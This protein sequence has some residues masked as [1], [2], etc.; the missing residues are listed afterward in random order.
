MVGRTALR[1]L[2]LAILLAGAPPL[3]PQ[4]KEAVL[5]VYNWAP[6]LYEDA[7]DPGPLARIVIGS[8][9]AVGYRVRVVGSS[10]ARVMEG[11]YSGEVDLSPGISITDERKG[12]MWFSAPLVNLKMG[13]IFKKGRIRYNSIDDLARF[14]GGVMHGTFWE[15]ILSDHGIRYEAVSG[16]EQNIQKL[17]S[18]RIDFACLPEPIA[19]H[20]LRVSGDDPAKYSF[21]LYRLDPQPVGISKA[22]KVKN[23]ASD[24]NRGLLLFMRTQA[25][26]SIMRGIGGP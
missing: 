16:Q 18:D 19:L 23:L 12:K 14:T 11:L 6:L 25:Y 10:F 22:T 21:V 1:S 3:L 26:M 2:L 9:E 17:I 7:N 15:K 13:F 4:T 5:A 20:L 8:L 24:F